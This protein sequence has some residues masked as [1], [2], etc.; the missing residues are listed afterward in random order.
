[1]YVHMYKPVGKTVITTF[2]LIS[3]VEKLAKSYLYS[4]MTTM[5]E[6]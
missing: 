2:L 1:M 3:T 5:F 4:E 6:I